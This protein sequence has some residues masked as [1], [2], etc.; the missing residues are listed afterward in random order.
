MSS[1]AEETAGTDARD[2]GSVFRV[3]G[4]TNTVAGVVMEW[5]A[6]ER[7]RSWEREQEAKKA[8]RKRR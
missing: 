8:R 2:L 1:G 4:V 3:R 5:E 7:L 6:L